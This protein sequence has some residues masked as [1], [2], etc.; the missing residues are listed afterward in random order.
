MNNE[1]PKSFLEVMK[2]VYNDGLDALD[3]EAEVFGYGH[4]EVGFMI[5]EKWGLPNDLSILIRYHHLDRLTA[6][7]KSELM[8]NPTTKLGLACIEMATKLCEIL[9]IGYRDKNASLDP[10]KLA[11]ASILSA[12]KAK[13]DLW[14]KKTQE[15]YSQERSIFN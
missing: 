4:P 7:Q 12:D 5:S 14:L 13:I 8:V 3:A 11:S 2:R 1:S 10:L 9:G 15:A 6:D